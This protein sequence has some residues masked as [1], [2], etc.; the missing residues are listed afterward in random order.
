MVNLV[1][2]GK[3]KHRA[4][5]WMALCLPGA[6]TKRSY[7]HQLYVWWKRADCRYQVAFAVALVDKIA[8]VCCTGLYHRILLPFRLIRDI[9]FHQLLKLLLVD[10]VTIDAAARTEP[11]TQSLHELL[12]AICGFCCA[13]RHDDDV[14]KIAP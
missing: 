13:A 9:V 11:V 4:Y 7:Q 14:V 5:S 8:C 2:I 3:K 10:I 1:S 12:E 6:Q